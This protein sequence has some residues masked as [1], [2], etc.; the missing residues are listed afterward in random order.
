MN[1]CNDC[2]W[3][4]RWRPELDHGQCY[5]T[6]PVV[7][8]RPH[9][10]LGSEAK[11]VR[12]EVKVDTLRCGSGFEPK[13]PQPDAH[14]WLPV[15]VLPPHDRSATG[16]S[17]THLCWVIDNQSGPK[18]ETVRASYD[19]NERAW[20]DIHCLEPLHGATHWKPEV[21]PEET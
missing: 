5:G 12:P 14:G 3:F 17:A 18:G 9:V 7:I 15:T 1:T 21:G 20:L 2:R 6:P 11:T 13:A 4:R 19:F 8:T 10:S 16:H